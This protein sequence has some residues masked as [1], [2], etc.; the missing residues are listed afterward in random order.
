MIDQLIGRDRA[1]VAAG[2]V[3]TAALTWV[4]LAPAAH[5]KADVLVRLAMPDVRSWA[6]AETVALFVMWAIVLITQLTPAAAPMALTFAAVARHR[7][8]LAPA[9]LTAAF[10]F[11][12]LAGWSIFAA[13]AALGQLGL[14]NGAVRVDEMT[15]T[16]PLLGSA[17]LLTA[18]AF[19]W[20]P[21]RHNAAGGDS[22]LA[23]LEDRWPETAVGAWGLGLRHGAAC[24]G[25]CWVLMAL[26]FV[27]GAMNFSWTAAIAAFL[28]AEKALPRGELIGRLAGVV[29]VGAGLLLIAGLWLT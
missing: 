27:A 22:P 10:V 15:G 14:H 29:F 8:P 16:S 24:V 11:G 18:G 3:G 2:L 23:F 20:T 13:T 12:H 9:A 17:L 5:S 4:Y 21:L 26:L 25:S 19:H 28:F 1:L 6:A 7:R